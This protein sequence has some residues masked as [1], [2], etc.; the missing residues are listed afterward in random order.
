VIIPFSLL[1]LYKK[2]FPL[3]FA[4]FSRRFQ[5]LLLLYLH[6]LLECGKGCADL[7]IRKKE[8]DFLKT[9]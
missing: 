7:L 9:S 2:G 8:R 6:L 3:L 5:F 1:I 4:F